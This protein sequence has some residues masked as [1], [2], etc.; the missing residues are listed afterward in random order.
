MYEAEQYNGWSNRETWLANLWLS[1]VESSYHLLCEAIA[2]DG[3]VYDKADWLEEQLRDRLDCEIEQACIWQ[4]LL[5]TAFGR[6]NWP[7]VIENNRE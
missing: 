6:I 7:E 2:I 4:D 3:S 5:H 1:N